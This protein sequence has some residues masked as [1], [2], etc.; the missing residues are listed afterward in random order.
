[1]MASALAGRVIVVIGA[2]RGIG[3]ATAAALTRHG[4]TVVLA[5]LDEHGMEEQRAVLTAQGAC[6]TALRVDVTDPASLAHL[7]ERVLQTCQRIDVLVNCAGVIVPGAVDALPWDAVRT[8]VE[9]NL[10]GTVN[11]TRAFLPYFR[12]RRG[13][14]FIHVA[15]LGGIVPLPGE[16]VYSAT[17]FAVRGFCLSLALELRRT[18]IA[19]SVI[20]PDSVDTAQLRTEAVHHGSP[21]SFLSPPLRSEEVAQAILETV[22][23]PRLEVAVPR[24]RG[25]SAT[26]VGGFPTLLGWLAPWLERQGARRRESFV[27]ALEQQ[28]RAGV[29]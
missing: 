11:V 12:R 6:L 8:Q 20:C 4:A 19:V 27:Q 15:S 23:Q 7:R 25:L 24:S 9:T 17:K 2:A 10:L 28:T 5:D 1:M 18:K 14:H 3:A 26:I 29:S 22:R 16:A 13:G 21:F